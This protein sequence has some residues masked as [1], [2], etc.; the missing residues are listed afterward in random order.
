MP[1]NFSRVITSS[2]NSILRAHQLFSCCHSWYILPTLLDTVRYDKWLAVCLDHEIDSVIVILANL[3][4]FVAPVRVPRQSL[5][6]EGQ[7]IAK[8][9]TEQCNEKSF[10]A[11]KQTGVARQILQRPMPLRSPP[12]AVFKCGLSFWIHSAQGAWEFAAQNWNCAR[13][14][15]ELGLDGCS[16]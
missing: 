12:P 2:G 14:C 16:T 8:F 5:S 6:Y 10:Q 15:Q 7:L 9:C 11:P 1:S 4:F 3:L 13:Q